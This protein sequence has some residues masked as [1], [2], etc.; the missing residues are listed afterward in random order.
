MALRTANGTWV[1]LQTLSTPLSGSTKAST[2]RASI[3]IAVM[4]G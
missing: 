1:E 2:A 4:R 3:G